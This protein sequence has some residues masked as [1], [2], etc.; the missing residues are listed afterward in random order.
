MD[1]PKKNHGR[2]KNAQNKHPQKTYTEDDMQLALTK[3]KDYPNLSCREVA[4]EMKI[5]EA[6]LRKRR[7][8]AT[9]S[10]VYGNNNKML[11]TPEEEDILKGYIVKQAQRGF[12]FDKAGVIN[13]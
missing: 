11:L 10:L 5:P 2:P 3:L 8:D 4:R 1:Q 12:G 9:I 7:N 13:F 6:T